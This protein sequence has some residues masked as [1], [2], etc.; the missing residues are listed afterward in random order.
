MTVREIYRFLDE[1]IPRT[2]SC[3]WDNDGLMCC[4]DGDRE[5]RRVLVTLDV[6]AEAVKAAIEGGYDVIVSHHPMIFKGLKA[7][8]EENYIAD[9]AMAL[10]RAGVAVMSFHTRLDAVGGGVNDTLA[11]LLGLADVEG[12]GEEGIGRI[13]TLRG[14]EALTEFA[15]RVKTLLGAPA[16][17]IAD[18]KKAVHRVAVLGGAGGDDVAA[19]QAAGADTYLSGTLGYHDLVDAPENGM[20]L[21]A[22]GHYYTEA[23]I[24]AVLCAWIAE[25]D[26]TIL[27]D[28]YRSANVAVI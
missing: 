28:T 21:V 8:N 11:A 20:N 14:E 17:A 22:A 16:V 15:A 7:I 4:P 9:K 13:G 1:K 18:G 23:P 27:C 12:F 6:T 19:A 10:I 25:A 5:V 26:K 24:C 2:L 3:A